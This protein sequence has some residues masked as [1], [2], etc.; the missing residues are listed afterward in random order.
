MVKSNLKYLSLALLA[1]FYGS[2][3]INHFRNPDF[4]LRAAMPE[5]I[6]FPEI[7]NY[8]GGALELVLVVLM[9]IPKTRKLAL[10]GIIALLIVFLPIHI[11]QIFDPPA[12]FPPIYVWLRVPVQFLFMAWA[13]YTR[14]AFA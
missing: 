3:G 2:A 13:Y 12:V 6:P 7:A 14:K 1:L 10:T 9:L 4:Y 11:Y 5:W 8:A